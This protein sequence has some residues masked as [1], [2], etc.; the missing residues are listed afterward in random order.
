MIPPAYLHCH[1]TTQVTS[2]DQP[3]LMLLV[4]EGGHAF[5]LRARGALERGDLAGFM[6]DLGRTQ[7]ALAELTQALDHVRG[8]D[9]AA[10]LERVYELLVGDL[11]LADAARCLGRI[12]AALEIFGSIVD[13]Y[14]RVAAG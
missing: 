7:D 9:V 2:V 3:R 4:L 13:A 12:D 6:A 11:A 5:L 1:V 8:G 10:R 14:R